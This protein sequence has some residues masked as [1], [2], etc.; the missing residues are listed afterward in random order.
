MTLNSSSDLENLWDLAL[1]SGL[2]STDELTL[3]QVWL[4]VDVYVIQIASVLDLNFGPLVMSS[5]DL[6]RVSINRTPTCYTITSLESLSMYNAE[7]I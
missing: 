3:C 4:L 1:P 5:V 6:G 7:T 2:T